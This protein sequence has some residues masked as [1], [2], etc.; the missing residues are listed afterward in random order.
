MMS[1]IRGKNTRPE[2]IVRRALHKA[3]FRFR[4]HKK[5]LP[6][7]PDIVLP[8]HKTV[9]FVHGCF[10]HKHECKYFKLPKTRQ[11][12]WSKKLEK[13]VERDYQHLDALRSLGWNVIQIW[14]CELKQGLQKGTL[15]DI[16]SKIDSQNAS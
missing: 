1:G 15:Q 13:N 6:G 3:G 12:F 2:M 11:E 8:K 4:L 14:E 16:I 9:I 7:E 10:W 5:D